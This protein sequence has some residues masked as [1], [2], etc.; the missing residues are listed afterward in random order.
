MEISDLELDENNHLLDRQAWTKSVA[1]LLA[2]SDGVQLTD[3][4][5]ALITAVQD[6]YEITGDTPPMRLLIK[7]LKT[8]LDKQIDSRHLYRLYPDG[9]VR[10]AS[11]HAGLPKPKHCM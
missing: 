4:H 2:K 6:L 10:L 1:T 11:R 7:F 9:P 8:T 5:W 3:D